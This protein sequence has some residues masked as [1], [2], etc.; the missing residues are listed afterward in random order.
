MRNLSYDEQFRYLL[1]EKSQEKMPSL[2]TQLRDMKRPIAALGAL[3]A[4]GAS[5][6]WGVA[7]V[8]YVIIYKRPLAASSAWAAAFAAYSAANMNWQ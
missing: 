3:G 1:Y 5:A 7:G 2:V 4:L 8:A 6:A